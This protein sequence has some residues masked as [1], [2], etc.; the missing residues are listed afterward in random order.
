M[1]V[2]RYI[3]FINIA[4]VM[5]IAALL[6]YGNTVLFSLVYIATFLFVTF[7]A[8][9]SA[10]RIQSR[11]LLISTYFVA[12]AL[13]V[14]FYILVVE[15]RHPFSKVFAVILLLLPMVLSHYVTIGKNAELYLPTLQEAATISFSQ[16]HLFAD[17]ITQTSDRLRKT[18]RS[19]S[20]TNFKRL[21]D[22][23]PKLFQLYQRGQPDGGLF[24][25]CRNQP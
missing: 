2:K 5:F 7:R 16:M 18:G 22:D 8:I 9:L 21:V 6:Y 3:T 19:L 20:P 10:G 1:N 11:F 23:L 14:A 15:S 17:K 4:I 13:Q 25:R 24:S 12:M